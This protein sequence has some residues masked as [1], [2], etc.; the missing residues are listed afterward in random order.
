MIKT[1]V[2]SVCQDMQSELNRLGI[3]SSIVKSEITGRL[4]GNSVLQISCICNAIFSLKVSSIVKTIKRVGFYRCVSCG[5]KAKH[6]DLSFQHNHRLGIRDSWTSERKKKQ[7]EISLGHWKDSEFRSKVTKSSTNTWQNPHKIKE[8]SQKIISLWKEEDFVKKQTAANPK[9][10]ETSSIMAR[11]FWKDSN[12]RDKQIVAKSSIE[13]LN[14]QR[15][16]AIERWNNPEYRKLISDSMKEY[17]NLETRS[18]WSDKM[19]LLWKNPEYIEKQRRANANP[20]L[21]KLKSENA[22]KQW[23]NNETRTK[24]ANGLAQYRNGS[25]DSILER[26][27]QNILGSLNIEYIRHHIIGHFEFDLFIPS[28]NILIE[29]NGEYWHS[30]RQS[31]D[32]SKFTYIDKYFPDLK[33]LYLWERDFLNPALVH[34]KIVQSLSLE[35]SNVE[36]KDFSFNDIHIRKMNDKEVLDKSYY[37]ACVEFLQSYHYAGYGRSARTVYGAY[38]G[39]IL[40]GICKYSNPVRL[41]SA[42]SM[43]LEHKNVLELD[44]FCVHPYYHKK[45]FSSWFLSRCMKM[46]LI[47]F[48]YISS[49]ISYADSTFGHFGTIYKATNWKKLH[50][51][52]PDYHYIS[53]DGFVIH[54]KTL[55]NHASRLKKKESDYADLFGYKKVF[56]KSKTKFCFNRP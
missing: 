21:L 19:I 33:I 9:R 48:P 11:E 20:E 56:G 25:K 34:Q 38:H 26:V 12:Y 32:A 16:L 24:I 37:S 54:K 3:P 18:L 8:A 10:S 27:T 36:I 46:T 35:S 28:H 47:E 53:A 50:E 40:V 23:E 5:M 15:D 2:L 42:T 30:N 39:D 43:G 17:F 31:Q 6:Q 4:N 52:R 55:Y 41:E 49:L 29:C 14:L 7:S 44:R 13:Y 1:F 45:N 51:T 22:K